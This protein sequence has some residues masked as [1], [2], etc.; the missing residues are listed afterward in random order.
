MKLNL[1]KGLE[2]WTRASI[3]ITL[4]PGQVKYLLFAVL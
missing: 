2:C 1:A 3:V 4:N